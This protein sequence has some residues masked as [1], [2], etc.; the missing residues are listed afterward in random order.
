MPPCHLSGFH[1][2]CH[3]YKALQAKAIREAGNGGIYSYHH[4]NVSDRVCWQIP[5]IARI[6]GERAKVPLPPLV[7]M[8]RKEVWRDSHCK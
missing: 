3:C 6:D 1:W 7:A 5:P 8:A 2:L 4:Q